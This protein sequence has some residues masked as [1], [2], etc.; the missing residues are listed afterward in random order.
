MAASLAPARRADDSGFTLVELLIAV[1]L[2]AIGFVV[3]L[4]AI[5]VFSQATSAHRTSAELDRAARTYAERLSGAAY[6]SCPADYS[7]VAVPSG[8]TSSVTIRYWNGT[9]TP[10]TFV[11]ACPDRGIQQLAITLTPASGGNH[12]DQLVIV[13]RQP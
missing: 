6:D 7:S 9:T 1:S 12:Q 3:I 10:A 4:T 13:K 8:F 2:M 11:A 5:G